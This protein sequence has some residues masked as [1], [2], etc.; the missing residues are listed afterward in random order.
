MT[1]M[2]RYQSEPN[3]ITRVFL[4]FTLAFAFLVPLEAVAERPMTGK[5]QWKSRCPKVS[6]TPMVYG[7]GSST[8]GTSLGTS[9]SKAL[10]KEG[11]KFRKWGKASSGLARPEFHDW[12]KSIKQVVRQKNPDIFVI[13]L[14]TNDF[15]ALYHK[16]KWIRLKEEKRWK[17]IYRE[18][19]ESAL[20]AASGREGK[21]MV[22]WITPTIFNSKK[23]IRAGKW[24]HDI[25]LEEAKHFGGPVFVVDAYDKTTKNGQPLQF[26]K[27]KNGKKLS[28]FGKDKIHLT[29]S[30]VDQLM[31]EPVMDLI[32]PCLPKKKSAP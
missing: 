17:Q 19:V 23:A 2:Y 29:Q 15:Q 32:R 26:F 8:M 21:R 11:I 31:A 1:N 14:G 18:R 10:K 28:I 27:T 6:K 30:A 22:I 25:V 24:I 12:P 7:I 4:I 5:G 20:E 16:K 3:R 13:S 9:L